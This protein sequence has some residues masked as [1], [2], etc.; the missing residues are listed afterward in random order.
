MGTRSVFNPRPERKVGTGS[1]PSPGQAGFPPQALTILAAWKGAAW[2]AAQQVFPEQNPPGAGSGRRSLGLPLAEPRPESS[3]D[4]AT[5]TP[6]AHSAAPGS[7]QLVCAVSQ[8][9]AVFVTERLLGF[10]PPPHTFPVAILSHKVSFISKV[11]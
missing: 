7:P 4:P 10:P 6:R 1:A 11:A 5:H 9:L 3:P 2:K 8:R